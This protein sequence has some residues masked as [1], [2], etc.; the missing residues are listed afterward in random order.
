M[1]KFL[2]VTHLVRGHYQYVTG[3]GDEVNYDGIQLFLG[4]E[5]GNTVEEAWTKLIE[6]GSIRRSLPEIVIRHA[7]GY[8]INDDGVQVQM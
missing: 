6:S 7:F 4:I 8:E 3:E 2:F 1:K 5:P